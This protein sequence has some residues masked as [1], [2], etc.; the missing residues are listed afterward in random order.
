M[1]V[2]LEER[3]I[4]S[5]DT[6][7]GLLCSRLATHVKTKV[8]NSKKHS[9]WS[10]KFVEANLGQVAAIMQLNSHIKPDLEFLEADKTLLGSENNFCLATNDESKQQ[11]AYLYF[12]TNNCTYIRSGKVTG[13][14]FAKR[15]SE[16]CKGAKLTLQTANR[17][18]FTRDIHRMRRN[19]QL[20]DLGRAALRISNSWLPVVSTAN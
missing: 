7:T 1:K 10:L 4:A 6:L 18:G 2:T 8:K 16:H 3:E 9:H 12:D 14:S 5:S 11:G 20:R 13:R 17:L 15:H 19:L